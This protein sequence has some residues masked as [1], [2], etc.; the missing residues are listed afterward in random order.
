MDV[1]DFYLFSNFPFYIKNVVKNK[2]K[3]M[4]AKNKVFSIQI[5]FSLFF[6]VSKDLHDFLV[7]GF[8]LLDFFSVHLMMLF[9]VFLEEV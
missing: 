4:N 7:K 1:T 8:K 6:L 9:L 3:I 2:K 5:Y